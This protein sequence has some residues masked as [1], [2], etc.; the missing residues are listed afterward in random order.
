M[1]FGLGKYVVDGGQT[2]R[3]SP[4]HPEHV[5]QLSELDLALRETQT[6]FYAMDLNADL[7]F[8]TDESMGLVKMTIRKADKLG[9]LGNVAS[10]YNPYDQRIYDGVQEGG[11]KL[12]TFANYL[13]YKKQPLV[14]I[15]K[16]VKKVGED[17]MRRPVEIEFA[18]VPEMSTFYLLQIRPIVDSNQALQE[19]LEKADES[20]MLLKSTHVLGHGIMDD[21]Y[22]VIYVKTEHYSRMDNEKIA[23]EVEELNAKMRAEGK[24][25][26]LIGPGRWG[27]SDSS[28]GAP[29][30]WSQIANVRV[31]VEQGLE[32]YYVEPSQGT[33][34]FQNLTSF[35]VGY[36]TVDENGRSGFLRG[37]E[38][39]KMTLVEETEHMKHVK[40]NQPLLVKMDGKKR[41]GYIALP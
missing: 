20:T 1:A 9:L 18:F 7:V 39:E 12:I 35:G 31:M 15:L 34:F 29:V 5:L 14:E 32:G 23:M 19:D 26:I 36:F 4:S 6:S 10:T 28:L 41:L 11:R 24:G 25:Y 17:E 3:F 22:D 27:S 38:L 16:M 8:S 33:H 13:K 37:G 2:L 30:R 40:S 21:V